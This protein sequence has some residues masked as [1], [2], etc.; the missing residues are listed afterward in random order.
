MKSVSGKNIDVAVSFLEEYS[1][2]NFKWFSHNQFQVTASKCYVLL[3]TDQHLQV[4]IGAEKFEIAQDK[5]YSMSQ[6]MQN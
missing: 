4:N 1:F 6:L 2:V 5:R 3:S